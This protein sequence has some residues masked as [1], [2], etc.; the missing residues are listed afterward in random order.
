MGL[1]GRN[2]LLLV[3]GAAACAGTSST[4]STACRAAELDLAIHAGAEGD[5]FF[6]ISGLAVGSDGT[7]YVLDGGE[8]SLI[9]FAPEGDELWRVRGAEAE[10]ADFV[11]P[12]WLHRQG[13][14]LVFQDLAGRRLSFWTEDGE[15]AGELELD[16]LALAGYPSWIAGLGSGKVAAALVPEPS[17]D[18]LEPL[19]G[20]L[21]IAAAGGLAVDTLAAFS[22]PAPQMLRLPGHEIPVLSPYAPHTTF[23]SWPEGLIALAPGEAYRV[24]VFDAAG[25]RRAEIRGDD[26]APA[27]TAADRRAFGRLLPDTLLVEQLSFPAAHPPITMIAATADGHLLVRTSWTRRDEVRWDRWTTEGEFVDSFL[28]PASM[29]LVTGV[30]NLVYGRAVDEVGANHLEVYRLTGAATCPGPAAVPS[31]AATRS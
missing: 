6:A 18:D 15:G 14:R 22:F 27:V 21:I 8:G 11:D 28:L 31:P 13:E 2:L 7:A 10:M 17:W 24:E 30:G 26:A 1:N 9:A 16:G 4:P 25:T 23:T 29:L 19:D 12:A 5:G 20:V 3:L